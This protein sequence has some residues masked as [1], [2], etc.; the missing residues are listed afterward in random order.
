MHPEVKL[1]TLMATRQDNAMSSFL[2]STR[3]A[4]VRPGSVMCSPLMVGG[5]SASGHGSLSILGSS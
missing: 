5:M 1:A 2:G 4:V 3:R